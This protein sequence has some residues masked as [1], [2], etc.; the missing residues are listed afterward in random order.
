MIIQ[1]C[2]F[3][4]V[5]EAK[6]AGIVERYDSTAFDL[7]TQVIVAARRRCLVGFN[8]NAA[9]HAKMAE[10]DEIAVE[11]DQNVFGA[12][13]DVAHAP[14]SDA[15]GKIHRQRKSEVGAAHLNRGD[16]AAFDRGGDA[17][18]DGLYFGQ[19][20]HGGAL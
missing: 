6:S 20:R 16:D 17:A 15:F 18:A 11:G 10:N 5:E 1:F 3:A 4:K 8:V 19:F 12:A 2:R 9:G 14:A 7:K 13:T